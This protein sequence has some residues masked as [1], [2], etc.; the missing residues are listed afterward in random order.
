[1]SKGIKW[2]HSNLWAKFRLNHYV[3]PNLRNIE[4]TREEYSKNVDTKY[5][6][7]PSHKTEPEWYFSES[8]CMSIK[9]WFITIF[10]NCIPLPDNI[11]QVVLIIFMKLL[12][13]NNLTIVLPL[14]WP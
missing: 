6:L 3:I 7:V 1:V 4:M 12:S 10:L 11:F 5:K 13:S 9:H 14:R 2:I 8:N